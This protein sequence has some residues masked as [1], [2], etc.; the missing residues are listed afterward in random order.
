[1]DKNLQRISY[2]NNNKKKKL[3]II[4]IYEDKCCT[5]MMVSKASLF[6]RI[7]D[8]VFSQHLLK[9]PST[10]V[11]PMPSIMSLVSLNGTYQHKINKYIKEIQEDEKQITKWLI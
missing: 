3:Y 4:A 1:M 9:T 7:T 2:V 8:R 11:T 6:V 5:S 10:P